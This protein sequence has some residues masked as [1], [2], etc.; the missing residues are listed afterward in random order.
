MRS[1]PI[2]NNK[3][4]GELLSLTCA[5]QWRSHGVT[6]LVHIFSNGRLL[7]FA[8]LQAK[9]GLPHSMY[10]PYLQLRHAIKAQTGSHLWTPCPAPVFHYYYSFIFHIILFHYMTEVSQFKGF[11]SRTYSMLLSIFLTGFPTKVIAHWE[12]D[13]GAFEEDQWEEVL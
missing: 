5:E 8:D 9:F 3:Y 10:F 7:S 2:W 4:Y 1:S 6:H 12:R 13:V 11:I